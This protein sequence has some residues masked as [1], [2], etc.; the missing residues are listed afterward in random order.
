[1]NWITISLFLHEISMANITYLLLAVIAG[2]VFFK[3]HKRKYQFVYNVL[4]FF[5]IYVMTYHSLVAFLMG[6]KLFYSFILPLDVLCIGII[7]YIFHMKCLLTR[8]EENHN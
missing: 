5:I 4:I 8:E 7:W 2:L 1:M 6:S 3:D